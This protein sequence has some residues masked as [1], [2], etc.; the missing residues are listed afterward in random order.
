MELDGARK[1]FENCLEIYIDI[2]AIFKVQIILSCAVFA[3]P[4][5][6]NLISRLAIQSFIYRNLKFYFK[7]D[8]ACDLLVNRAC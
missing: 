3:L 5:Y 7:S 8:G 2:G 4:M 6:L 1:L